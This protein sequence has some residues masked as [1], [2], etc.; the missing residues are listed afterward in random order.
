MLFRRGISLAESR[1]K[2]VIFGTNVPQL[3]VVYVV[4]ADCRAI[5]RNVE[6]LAKLATSRGDRPKELPALLNYM[7]VGKPPRTKLRETAKNDSRNDQ[8]GKILHC[9]HIQQGL[10]DEVNLFE[11]IYENGRYSHCDMA[12]DRDQPPVTIYAPVS[13]LGWDACGLSH[14]KL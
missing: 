8:I 6:I 14:P 11:E 10:A 5:S 12:P 2:A 1:A 7:S 4:E 3:S 9:Q 13:P